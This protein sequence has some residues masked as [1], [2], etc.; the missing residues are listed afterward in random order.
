MEFHGRRFRI[1]QD[2]YPN[3]GCQ[4][5]A[6]EICKLTTKSYIEKQVG[7]GPI[8]KGEKRW[9]LSDR[10]HHMDAYMVRDGQWIAAIDHLRQTWHVR[11][12]F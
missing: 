2:D 6:F 11:L 12:D 4:L 3:Y 8:L 5:F 7:D 1:A 10:I 9:L